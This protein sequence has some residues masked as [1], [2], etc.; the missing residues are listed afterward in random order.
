MNALTRNVYVISKMI[1]RSKK[2][3]EQFLQVNYIEL[4]KEITSKKESR[5][6]GYIPKTAFLNVNCYD[7]IKTGVAIATLEF[8]DQFDKFIVSDIAC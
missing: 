7:D 8:N 5:F 3:G 1:G 4:D 2:T 6:V